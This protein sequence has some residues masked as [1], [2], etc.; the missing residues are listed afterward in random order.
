MRPTANLRGFL[1]GRGASRSPLL[2][3]D[4]HAMPTVEFRLEMVRDGEIA[5]V[6]LRS[7]GSNEERERHS[8]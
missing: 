1:D 7:L 3:I 6:Y 8:P 2:R 5:S 4:P